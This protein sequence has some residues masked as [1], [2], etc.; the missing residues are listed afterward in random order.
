MK[1]GIACFSKIS[2]SLVLGSIKGIDEHQIEV[3]PTLEP[4][5][6]K[7]SSGAIDIMIL[8]AD[9][10]DKKKILQLHEGQEKGNGHT[11]AV[12][13]GHGDRKRILG[14]PSS[15]RLVHLKDLSLSLSA[16]GA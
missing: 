11:V 5:E 13:V 15:L 10:V 9:S 6:E 16:L 4:A 7:V 12:H 2:L 1:I 3:F 14:A 8:N